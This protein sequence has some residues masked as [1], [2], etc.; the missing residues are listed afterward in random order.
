MEKIF[1]ERV[2]EE[3]FWNI[4]HPHDNSVKVRKVTDESIL[5]DYVVNNRDKYTKLFC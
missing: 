1:N 3:G 2:F 4:N 5:P